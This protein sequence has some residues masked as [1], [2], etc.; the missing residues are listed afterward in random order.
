MKVLECSSKGD[1]RFSA[2]GAKIKVFGKLNT[3]ENHYQLSKRFLGSNGEVVIPKSWK[4]AKGKDIEFF[5]I[6]GR[7]FKPKYLTAFYDLMWVKYLDSN[8]DLVKYASKFDDF[9]DMF[10]GKSINCQADTI[11]KYIKEGRKSIMEDELVKEFIKLCKQPQE[12][13]EKEG[14]LL[15][16]NLDILAHQ[17]NCMGVMG[18]GIALSI[19]NKYPKVFSQYKQVTNSYK[20]K[21]QLMGRCLLISEEG[22]IIKLDNRIENNNVKII[23][24]LFGQY[25]YGKGLQTDY[26]A[27]KKALLELKKFA[28][29]NNLSIGIPYGIGCGN[30][31]GDWNI[32]EGII[33]DVFRNY[34]VVIY[35]L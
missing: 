34:P 29:N 24:N 5:E 18:A 9:T 30:A 35:S 17:S 12:I 33:E 27:L 28:Q 8:P 22:K 11:R 6:N 14:D 3:I 20:D 7:K 23:A 10:K 2:F 26:Q 13:I 15:E 4:E 16:S 19:K 32:V 21:K 25:S 1:I 31:G